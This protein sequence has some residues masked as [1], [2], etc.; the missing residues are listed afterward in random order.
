MKNTFDS[1]E[2]SMMINYVLQFRAF[3][4]EITWHPDAFNIL[5]IS[6]SE[7]IFDY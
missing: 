3:C 4:Y 2:S 7:V 6:S 5:Q 1:F